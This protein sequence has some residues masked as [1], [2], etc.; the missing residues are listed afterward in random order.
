MSAALAKL[1]CGQGDSIDI[2]EVMCPICLSILI[3]PVR[4]PCAH[5]LCM[6]CFTSNVDQASLCCPICRARISSWC[7]RATKQNKLIEP[8]LW[9]FIQKRFEGNVA[10]HLAGVDEEDVDDMFPCLPIH[11][12]ASQGAI[13]TEFENEMSRVRLEEKNMREEEERLSAQ[14]AEQI[15]EEER[16]AVMAAKEQEAKDEEIARKLWASTPPAPVKTTRVLR[17]LENQEKSPKTFT[18]KSRSVLEM[19]NNKKDSNKKNINGSNK[20]EEQ[21]QQTGESKIITPVLETPKKK[22]PGAL[23]SEALTQSPL[24]QYSLSK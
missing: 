9:E 11:Q 21:F 16:Q 15:L 4:M 23:L 18:K 3:E 20:N 13:K 2:S 1:Q 6:T 22:S 8:D 12:F 24:S 17:N 14:L 10:S 5:I 19:M 7:R